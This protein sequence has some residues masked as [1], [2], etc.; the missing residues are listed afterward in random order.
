MKNTPYI[1]KYII[2]KIKCIHYYRYGHPQHP[3]TAG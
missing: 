2:L 1:F 3:T